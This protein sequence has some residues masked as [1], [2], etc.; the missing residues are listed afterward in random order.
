VGSFVAVHASDNPC[1][2]HATSR[3]QT[4]WHLV[5]R[6]T[7]RA[8]D[9][10]VA[11]QER[12]CKRTYR[13]HYPVEAGVWK[14]LHIPVNYIAYIRRSK[15]AARMSLRVHLKILRF[16]GKWYLVMLTTEQ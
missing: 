3:L 15:S 12:R 4:K 8:N 14:V 2:M 16:K 9:V 7:G 10:R 5:M 1:N 13:S 6:T 11:L